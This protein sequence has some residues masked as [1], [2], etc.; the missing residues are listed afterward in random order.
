MIH[1]LKSIIFTTLLFAPVAL[2]QAIETMPVFTPGTH[3]LF[4]GDSITD[5]NRGRNTAT[6]IQPTRGISSW[7]MNGSVWCES[8][9]N[10]LP[11]EANIPHP[12][13]LSA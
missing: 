9:G 13:R 12:R 10:R 4:Q 8:F 11:R 6:P 2:L 7:P 5:G 1:E 3:I